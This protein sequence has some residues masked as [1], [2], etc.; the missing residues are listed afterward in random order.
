[1]IIVLFPRLSISLQIKTRSKAN[2]EQKAR[3][4]TV[5]TKDY[6]ANT[7]TSTPRSSQVLNRGK[8]NLKPNQGGT[9]LA[10]SSK[11][12]AVEVLA[13][14]E[15]TRH[16]NGR[17]SK[18]AKPKTIMT[19]VHNVT[20]ASPPAKRKETADTP[21][22]G[23]MQPTAD[24]GQ[25]KPRIRTR[26][27]TIDPSQSVIQK[28]M[29]QN[30]NVSEI[31]PPAL[32][33]PAPPAEP[34]PSPIA[35]EISLDSEVEY[36]DDFESYESDFESEPSEEKEISLH[37]DQEN[38]KLLPQSSNGRVE[39]RKLDSGHYDLPANR[40]VIDEIKE[41]TGKI[42]I[43]KEP[44]I[45]LSQRQEYVMKTLDPIT[46]HIF[47]QK[48]MAYDMHI[49]GHLGSSEVAVQYKFDNICDEEMQ[50]DPVQMHSRWTQNP[51]KFGSELG[52]VQNC[53]S[54][55]V[56]E[57]MGVGLERVDKELNVISFN[58]KPVDYDRLNR[59][60]LCSS[61]TISQI[62][63]SRSDD[64]GEG[65]YLSQFNDYLQIK[66]NRVSDKDYKVKMVYTSGQIIV[67]VL[68]PAILSQPEV[69]EIYDILDLKAPQ[70]VLV[71]WQNIS[72]VLIHSRTPSF[73]LGGSRDGSINLWDWKS[74]SSYE[75]EKSSGVL[76]RRPA[77]LNFIPQFLNHYGDFCT[78]V[79]LL[80]LTSDNQYCIS[81][82]DVAALYSIGII[83]IWS[84]DTRGGSLKEVKAID[85]TSKSVISKVMKSKF[86]KNISYF[87]NH[88]FQDAALKELQTV[89]TLVD[90]SQ[91][92]LF[93]DMLFE[94]QLL[95]L[96][97]NQ[98]FVLITSMGLINETRKIIIV[99]EGQDIIRIAAAT[100]Y[101]QGVLLIALSD[102]TMKLQNIEQQT[103]SCLNDN[104]IDEQEVNPK[105]HK[106]IAEKS[107]AIQ[108]I[109]LSERKVYDMAQAKRNLD[110][111][112]ANDEP[113]SLKPKR[114]F[115]NGH[116]ERILVHGN[117]FQRSSIRDLTIIGT[118][119]EP[120][121]VYFMDNR[122]LKAYNVMSGEMTLADIKGGQPRGISLPRDQDGNLYMVIQR[123]EC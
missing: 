112:E 61:N 50:T 86:E 80:E 87:E 90:Q 10:M 21:A 110:S 20:V 84:V 68:E 117:Y 18:D 66:S 8:S 41:E 17:F 114:S 101:K 92:L 70:S 33:P 113:M 65:S 5:A 71:S 26:T 105:D 11:K 73:L 94:N 81:G 62:V 120:E 40:S 23:Q 53:T 115:K 3:K 116:V 106:L 56:E 79:K 29:Q 76:R 1:M 49:F 57:A 19:T 78:L 91:N 2:T 30:N 96:I 98:N 38:I 28:Y 34:T 123:F 24:D 37:D 100:I 15:M 109:V 67:I 44:K 54:K 63:G 35:F 74:S 122:V 103:D 14:A 42:V 27:R 72:S 99:T 89:K 52:V 36:E 111:L 82:E 85:L 12:R 48:P 107:C 69:L 13:K 43:D 25:Q 95:I 31:G 7:T 22:E 16:S 60:L 97:S 119:N 75:M 118:R 104:N 55:Y 93:I 108:N 121:M 4:T 83:V 47:E 64:K 39:E 6:N 88:I 102:G 32:P 59:F 45:I 51:P 9:P 77:S 58:N 46:F